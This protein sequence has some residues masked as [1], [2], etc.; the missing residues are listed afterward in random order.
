M[1]FPGFDRMSPPSP[2]LH[3]GEL[4]TSFVYNEGLLDSTRIGVLHLDRGGS[5]QAANAL[6]LDI[7]RRRGDG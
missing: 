4:K 5:M 3:P 6:A 2:P 1:G 7:L